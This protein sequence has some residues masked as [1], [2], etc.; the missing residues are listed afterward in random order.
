MTS[1]TRST[2]KLAEAQAPFFVGVDVGGTNIK[3]G[4]VDDLGRTLVYRRIPTQASD[5]PEVATKRM[6]QTVRE[7]VAEAG[8]TLP[9]VA[10]VGLGTPG[11]MNVASGLLIHPHNLP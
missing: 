5:G 1:Q 11:T 3:L 7:M 6:G 10:R 8:L 9:Y 4:V 2:V